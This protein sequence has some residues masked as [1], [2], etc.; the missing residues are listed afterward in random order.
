M[1]MEGN[2]A[3]ERNSTPND[4][5]RRE[6]LYN[7]LIELGTTMKLVSSIKFDKRNLQYVCRIPQK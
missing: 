5:L 3:H 7:I 4:S 1:G 2:I 6:V